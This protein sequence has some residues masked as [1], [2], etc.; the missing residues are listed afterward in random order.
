MIHYICAIAV[1][2]EAKLSPKLQTEKRRTVISLPMV[3]DHA[4]RKSPAPDLVIG[5][6]DA[7]AQS[8]NM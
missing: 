8:G 2:G 6:L 4:V 3:L 7:S 1:L 5:R